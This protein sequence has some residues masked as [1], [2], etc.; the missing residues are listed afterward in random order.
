MEEQ[1]QRSNALTWV[2]GTFVWTVRGFAH[3]HT[4]FSLSSCFALA[5]FTAAPLKS[6][7]FTSQHTRAHTHTHTTQL[8]SLSGPV[9]CLFLGFVDS[10]ISVCAYR[11]HIRTPLA[12]RLFWRAW[13]LA[14]HLILLWVFR[15]CW[16]PSARFPLSFCTN[17][18]EV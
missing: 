17:F 2:G 6:E 7:T 16:Y 8:S 9:F 12:P 5:L 10:A 11:T 14:A 18:L 15:P 4:L 1:T 3:T 13:P